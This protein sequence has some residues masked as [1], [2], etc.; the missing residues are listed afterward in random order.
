MTDNKEHTPCADCGCLVHWL[1]R[2]PGNRCLPCH[3]RIVDGE[4]PE[5]TRRKII[6]GFGGRR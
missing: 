5:E 6:D 4:T 3:A 2:F 1:E